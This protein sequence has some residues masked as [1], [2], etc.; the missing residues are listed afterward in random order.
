[1]DIIV[2]NKPKLVQLLKVDPI[3]ILQ[4]VQSHAL[5]TNTEYG[6][7]KSIYRNSSEE[8]VAIE[9]LDILCGKGENVCQSFLKMLEDDDV[10]ENCPELR[11]WIKTVETKETEKAGPSN[12]QQNLR[13]T[14]GVSATDQT[15]DCG[16][17]E[18][19]VVTDCKE[20]LK[21]NHSSLVQKVKHID[22]ILDDLDLH[23][24]AAANVRSQGTN[25]DK[26][27]KLLDYMNSK[28]IAEHLVDALFKHERDLMDD[29]LS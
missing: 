28:A 24:E 1:M 10:N 7:L 21:T 9:L 29:L 2:K 3:R 27:R 22:V 25:Q 4:Y 15:K 26:M 17:G 11:A 5:I 13:P 16:R 6:N 14:S 19:K 20:F 12:H 8:N 18:S 23:P